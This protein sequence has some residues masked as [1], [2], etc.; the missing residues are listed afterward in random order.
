MFACEQAP[1]G[2]ACAY[3]DFVGACLHANGRWHQGLKPS[4]PASRLLRQGGE[5]LPIL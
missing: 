1:T 4:S 5:R 3:E 2:G